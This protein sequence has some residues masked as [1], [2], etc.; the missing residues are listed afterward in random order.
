MLCAYEADFLLAAISRDGLD[1]CWGLLASLG[2][3]EK[4]RS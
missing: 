3:R 1:G 4:R 2:R